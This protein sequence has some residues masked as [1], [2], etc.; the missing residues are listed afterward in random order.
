VSN[1]LGAGVAVVTGADS[2][3]FKFLKGAVDSLQSSRLKYGYDLIVLDFGLRPEQVEEFTESYK[4]KVVTPRWHF[5]AP[6]ECVRRENLALAV[7]P[8][9]PQQV[10][11]YEIYLWFDGDAWVQDDRFFEAYVTPARTGKLVIAREDDRAYKHDCMALKWHLGNMLLGF[12]I[13][14][15]A[16]MLAKPPIN[17]GIW[18]MH[19]THPAWGL[20]A[21]RYEAVLHKTRKV[22]LDQHALLAAIAV[23]GPPVELLSGAYNWICARAHPLYDRETGKYCVP[24]GDHESLAVLHLAGPHKTK[25]YTVSVRQ[26]GVVQRRLTYQ[27]AE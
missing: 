7:R 22:N 1:S 12:G 9:L 5:D 25:L 18:A 23:D 15:S 17:A 24:H 8:Y 13:R 11:G 20:W 4:V 2:N 27:G 10:P 6:A 21:K 26:G 3:Y 16:R 14:D 19:R